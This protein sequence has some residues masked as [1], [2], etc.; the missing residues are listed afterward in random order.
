MKARII[1]SIIAIVIFTCATAVAV[2]NQGAKDITLD[3]GKKGNVN[4]PHHLH[5]N[6]IGD[7]KACHDLFPKTAGTIKDFKEQGKL[8]K[9]QV[10]NKICIEC[11]KL[12]EKAGEKAGP[13][14]CSQCHVK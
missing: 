1:M 13:T 5:Q 3:G 6:A 2:E 4:F 10:M 7:C 12:K 14:K 8:K 9:M 11:H